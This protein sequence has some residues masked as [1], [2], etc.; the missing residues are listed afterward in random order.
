MGQA[1]A[2]ERDGSAGTKLEMGRYIAGALEHHHLDLLHRHHLA[3]RGHVPGALCE[4][5]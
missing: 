1:D 4:D 5:L 2:R 3:L